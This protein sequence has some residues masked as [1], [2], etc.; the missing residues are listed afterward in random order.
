MKRGATKE[1]EKEDQK[2]PKENLHIVT[3]Q[4]TTSK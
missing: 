1:S 2:R 4:D 3:T